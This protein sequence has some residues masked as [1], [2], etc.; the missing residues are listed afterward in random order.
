MARRRTKKRTHVGAR[1]GPSNGV[2]AN[3][4]A[5]RE[6]KSMVI[7][8]GAGEVGPSVSQLVKDV[9]A[10]M[11]PGTA[12]RLKERRSNRL[13][14]YTAMAG[15]LG[16]SHLLLFS[17]STTGNTNLRLALTPRGPTLHFRV[18]KYSLCKD[19]RKA[20]KHPQGGGKEYLTAPLLVM[21]NFTSSPVADGTSPAVPKHLESLTTTIFQSLFPP[22]SPQSTPLSSIRRVLLLNREL[23]GPSPRSTTTSESTSKE[24]G[25]Y[26]LNLRHYAITT[27]RTGLSRGIRRL[28]A[29]EKV[30]KQKSKSRRGVPNLGKL[31]D[32]ADYLLDPSAAAAASGGFTSGSESEA[33]TDAEVEVLETN[34][35]KVLNKKQMA[36]L[37]AKN[38][39]GKQH[40]GGQSGAEKRAVKLTEL[41]PRLKLRMTKVEEGV[42]GGKVMW[43]EFL[44]KSAEEVKEMERVWEIRRKEREERRRVQRDNV[45]RKRKERG[46]RAKGAARDNKGERQDR[47]E[48]MDMHDDD[49][50]SDGLEGAG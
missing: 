42:C 39:D 19:V 4:S 41:G 18:Q 49:W 30:L 37:R 35:R 21:N 26:V 33:E 23:P 36:A 17:R 50:E 43:H 15:P 13:R 5:S 44:E 48:D 2:T 9:R 3:V 8:I 29:A 46:A 31:E 40:P 47:D 16:I 7:R 34:A 22:I 27:R 20:Q 14:D 25:T 10:M 1:N 32:V 45:E 24:S 11:E 6:P 38:G 28:N 12:I